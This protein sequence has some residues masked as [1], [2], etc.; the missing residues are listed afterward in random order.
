MSSPPKKPRSSAKPAPLRPKGATLAEFAPL[1]PAEE[2]LVDAC[3]EGEVAEIETERPEAMTDAN[4]IRPG[5]L[6]VLCLGS[7][8]L[9][10]VH[11]KGVRLQG[12]WI[13]GALDLEGATAPWPISLWRCR[14]DGDVVLRDAE[15]RGL[16]LDGTRIQA[17]EGARLRCH[18]DLFLRGG[19]HA[20][21]AVSLLGAT[22]GGNLECS[23]GTFE[24]P[25]GFALTCD[26]VKITGNLFLNDRFHAKGEVRLPGATIGSDLACTGGT[27]E[28]PGGLALV[29][30]RAEVTGSVFLIDRFHAKGEFRLIGATFGLDVACTGGTFENPGDDALNLG[31]AEV[32]CGL[33]LRYD[34]PDKA[35]DDPDRLTRAQI[36]GDLRLAGAK[37][38]TVIDDPQAWPSGAL[39]LDGLRYDHFSSGAPTDAASRIVWLERQW[40]DHLGV[41]FKPQP[42][43]QC[44]KVLAAMGHEEEA[45]TIRI[46]KRRRQWRAACLRAKAAVGAAKTGVTVASGPEAG[47]ARR[48]L[49]SA[50]AQL[51]G[52]ALLSPVNFL[53]RM[54]IGY[55]YRPMRAL[56][57]LFVIWLLGIGVFTYAPA[58]IMA[59][60][61]SKM[62]LDAS[63]PPECRFDWV[64]YA[65]PPL[66]PDTSP[67][68]RADDV[69]RAREAA[70]LRLPPE[71]HWD[72]ICP[73][74]VP[75]E[76]STFSP[77]VYAAD[78]ILPLVDLRQERDWAPRV[79]G[80]DGEVLHPF[81]LGW[82][83]GHLV[84]AWEWFMILSGWVLSLLFA[85]AVSGIVR[86]DE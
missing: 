66:P 3:R 18:S 23:G 85:A 20:K 51:W 29:C 11:E 80:V 79:T 12:A 39:W 58:G 84:R 59:P 5:V 10:P 19:F 81:G 47:A 76:Y 45:K 34:N 46:E 49:W 61:D 69:R 53:F 43:E 60:T 82:G 86:R 8:P 4:R 72:A 78:L 65:R 21:G 67:L 1:L 75:S 50:R 41:D 63:I 2:K 13:D 74:R 17:L 37:I 77:M 31:A 62:Y 73:R 44:A 71:T 56:A 15:L 33:W 35:P 52:T 32:K 55:G 30:D 28:N 16:G 9:A 14:I 68:Q 40:L 42:W 22:I 27:F 48:A 36:D 24:N 64:T 26:G 6:R 70:A 38:D 57:A 25:G 54:L 83:L 7:D